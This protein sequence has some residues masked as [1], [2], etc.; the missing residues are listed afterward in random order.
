MTDELREAVER[1][2]QEKPQA[3][4]EGVDLRSSRE[5]DA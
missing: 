3:A 4:R 2:T 5:Y 1:A